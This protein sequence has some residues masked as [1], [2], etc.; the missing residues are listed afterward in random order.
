MSRLPRFLRSNTTTVY[1][2]VSRTAL[3]GLP[4]KDEDK[5]YMLDL[6]RKYS[7]LFFVD[8]MGFCIMGNHLHLVCQLQS[9]QHY[10]RSLQHLLYRSSGLSLWCW[11]CCHLS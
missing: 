7:K 5:D 2:V 8:I 10:Q 11:H 6:V 3:D 1:H 9:K 4:I